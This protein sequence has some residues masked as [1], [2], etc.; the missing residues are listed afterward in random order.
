MKKKKSKQSSWY[1]KGCFY[2]ANNWNDIRTV[3]TM[4]WENKKVNIYLLKKIRHIRVKRSFM[5]DFW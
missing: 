4:K 3:N 5:E 1:S 2:S